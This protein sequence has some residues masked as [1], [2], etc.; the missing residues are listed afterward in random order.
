MKW[1]IG[2]AIA[3]VLVLAA[4]VTTVALRASITGSLREIAGQ[5]RQ[6]EPDAADDVTA[7]LAW[8]GDDSVPV[9]E[10]NRG[11]W[12]LGQLRDARALP[13]L[14][15]LAVEECRHGQDICQHELQKAVTLCEGDGQDLLRIR[16]CLDPAP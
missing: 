3:L 4:V 8:V 13:V 1:K 15:S 9:A 11:V 6:A 5:A 10:R 16:G 12:A 2:G 7:L 14:R